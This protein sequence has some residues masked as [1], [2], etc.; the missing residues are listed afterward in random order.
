MYNMSQQP[1][2]YESLNIFNP[3]NY[4]GDAGSEK[5]DFSVAQGTETFPNGIILGDGTFLNSATGGGGSGVTNPMTG[6]LNAGGF[7]V[8]NLAAPTASTDAVTLAYQQAN[9][10]TNPMSAAL[11]MGG[12]KVFDMA[13][14]TANADAV[15]LQ[16]ANSTYAPLTSPSFSG[17]VQAPTPS[18]GI[19]NTIVPTTQWTVSTIS[20]TLNNSPFLGGNPKSTTPSASS[21]D[22][23]IATTAWVTSYYSTLPG[24]TGPQGPTG[25][26]AT[27]PT[28]NTGPTGPT[29][30]TG[31]TGTQG[32]TGADGGGAGNSSFE[33]IGLLLKGLATIPKY[34]GDLSVPSSNQ[35][36][37]APSAGTST[38]SWSTIY[39]PSGIVCVSIL[40]GYIGTYNTGETGIAMGVNGTAADGGSSNPVS[41][42]G[43]YSKFFVNLPF[44]G[45]AIPSNGASWAK[46][47]ASC[48]QKYILVPVQSQEGLT[49]AQS[50]CVVY[51]SS[52]YG[53]TTSVSVSYTIPSGTFTKIIPVPLMSS[54]GKRQVIVFGWIS[55]NN[56]GQGVSDIRISDNYGSSFSSP[57]YGLGAG[58]LANDCALLANGTSAPQQYTS[59]CMSDNGAVFFYF[60]VNA[61]GNVIMVRSTDGLQTV[62]R[63]T[64]IAGAS[65]YYMTSQACCSAAGDTVYVSLIKGSGTGTYAVSGKVYCS[66]DYGN[67]W[68]DVLQ[69]I[70]QSTPNYF[71][72]PVS[73]IA[74]D[75]TGQLV[76]ASTYYINVPYGTPVSNS[77]LCY[78]RSGSSLLKRTLYLSQ[79]N[80]FYSMSSMSPNG[81][82]VTYAG[83]SGLYTENQFIE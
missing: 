57:N 21:N 69:E 30:N 4:P 5:L 62:T 82:F 34:F 32:P 9:S 41:Y 58:V 54:S 61:N 20:D 64:L 3:V 72:G 42:T 36:T 78:S 75:S 24:P 83:G 46:G 6:D 31:P 51:A 52:D 74:C 17:T 55:G 67:S 22:T 2:P 68:Q 79:G 38:A 80:G 71:T 15:N 7:T 63:T 18:L 45:I 16:Y 11:D 19:S 59:A 44:T 47:A 26:G 77:E 10:L 33:G 76:I 50:G 37:Y 56:S 81:Q 43:P 39:G 12:F 65:P 49:P 25:I 70:G 14:P 48:D 73:S 8:T 28:G 66:N 40:T 23:D 29:G 13:N 35:F 53:Q 1:K 60:Y 27:G